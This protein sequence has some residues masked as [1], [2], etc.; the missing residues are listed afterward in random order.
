MS[1]SKIVMALIASCSLAMTSLA[2]ISG[3][4]SHMPLPGGAGVPSGYISYTVSNITGTPTFDGTWAAPVMT[5]WLGTFTAQGDVPSSGVIGTINYSS[6]AAL[7]ATHLPSGTVFAFGDLDNRGGNERF[8]LRA[9]DT[10]GSL[11]T[12]TCFLDWPQW[13][14]GTG[15][16]ATAM[17]GY[18]WDASS[19][20]LTLDGQ[21]VVSAINPNLTIELLSL[22]NISRLE[23]VKDG[24][25][26]GFGL[27]APMVP[28]PASLSLLGLGG[29]LAARRRR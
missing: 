10:S 15:M 29:L 5:P 12:G 8:H 14:S 21:T 17:P 16:S 22:V 13:V 19:G 25:L 7:S 20:V 1:E 28:S 23:V 4:G 27:R 3:S 2:Q 18:H 26:N 11:I 6:F 24:E 9:W